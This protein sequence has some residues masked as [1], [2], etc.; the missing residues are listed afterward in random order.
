MGRTVPQ[1]QPRKLNFP[2]TDD[3]QYNTYHDPVTQTAPYYFPCMDGTQQSMY[4]P[5]Q[6]SQMQTMDNIG[7]ISHTQLGMVNNISSQKEEL[8]S[9]LRD[10][11]DAEDK[12]I[13]TDVSDE[14][15]ERILDYS[16]LT[17]S[18]LAEDGKPD[19][20]ISFFPMKRPG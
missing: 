13:Q 1:R 9:L 4:V 12:M 8:L 2:G 20:A 16:D 17:A 18:P 14:D 11:Q 10:E 3:M 6:F 5:A 19:F 7:G 15:L